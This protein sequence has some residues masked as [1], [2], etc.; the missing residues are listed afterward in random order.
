MLSKLLSTR[1]SLVSLA[2]FLF[3]PYP[4]CLS[5]YVLH[6]TNTCLELL[7]QSFRNDRS[8]FGFWRSD[9]VR[10]WVSK[11]SWRSWISLS[12]IKWRDHFS[13]YSEQ[14]ASLLFFSALVLITKCTVLAT[15]RQHNNRP[16]SVF[17]AREQCFAYLPNLPNPDVPM[18]IASTLCLLSLESSP[19]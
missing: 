9:C 13:T 17:I 11:I 10:E 18:L 7:T 8:P 14:L 1:K 16:N 15:P 19:R 5:T 6:T 4:I 2:R 3:S 12:E